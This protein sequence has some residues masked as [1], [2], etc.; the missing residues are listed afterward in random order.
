M[1]GR[2]LGAVRHRGMRSIWSA[3]YEVYNNTSDQPVYIITEDNPWVKLADALIGEIPV[4][5]MFT[6]YMFHPTYTAY[7]GADKESGTP[8]LKLTKQPAFF[9]STF[10]IES[11]DP[12]LSGE[13]ETR[14]LLSL[15]MMVQMER[16]R[17]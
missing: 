5:G 15:L 1:A 8:V 9:E 17:G 11:V 12:T 14:L 3:T 6:G 13:E 16:S 7:R 4:V 10:T 2:E